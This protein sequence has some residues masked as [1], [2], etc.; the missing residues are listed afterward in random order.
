MIVKLATFFKSLP[1]P[2]PKPRRKSTAKYD[3]D[4]LITTTWFAVDAEQNV[5]AFENGMIPPIAMP[6][7]E[8]WRTI[9]SMLENLHANRTYQTIITKEDVM[10]AHLRHRR[11]YQGSF[12]QKLVD[13]SWDHVSRNASEW[14]RRGFYQFWGVE[15]SNYY[16]PEYDLVGKPLEP[17]KLDELPEPAKQVIA[18][19]PS[20]T[21][22]TQLTHLNISKLFSD[23]SR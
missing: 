15:S 3:W 6:H 16:P 18:A 12:S 19:I 2:S 10:A 4:F 21:R 11:S 5:A 20:A 9:E 14:T 23:A 1:R 17:I 7:I 8:N 13:M 22:F